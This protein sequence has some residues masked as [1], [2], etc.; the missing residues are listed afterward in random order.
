MRAFVR[1]PTPSVLDEIVEDGT[2]KK[3][4]QMYGERYAQNRANSNHTI[5]FQWPDVAKKPINQHLLTDLEAMTD[6][7]CS[8]CDKYPPFR[9]DDSIDHFK[10]KSWPEFYHEVCKWENLYF[11]CKHCQD[12]KGNQYDEQ[13]LRP[14][15]LGYN[16][17]D[18]FVY[19]YSTHKLSPNPSKSPENQKRAQTTIDIFDLN[20]T[21]MTIS[22]RY[23]FLLFQTN[24]LP[25]TEYYHRF[26][27]G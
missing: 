27:F 15:E 10:P 11:A 1:T 16:F 3:R 6:H 2:G 18:Y 12:A 19:D 20:H 24:Q 7:H 14:D 17:S 22:R 23:A 25:S 5:K 9:G 13:L 26:V 4:W 21:S 8:Y